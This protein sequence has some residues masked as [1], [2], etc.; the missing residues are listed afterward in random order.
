VDEAEGNEMKCR[1]FVKETMDEHTAKLAKFKKA[2]DR[3]MRGESVCY[4]SPKPL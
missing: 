1:H 2:S 3:H 4:P